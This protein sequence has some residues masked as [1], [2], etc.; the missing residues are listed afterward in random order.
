MKEVG[1]E[2]IFSKR[3]TE[4]SQIERVP[5]NAVDLAMELIARKSQ[6]HHKLSAEATV[7]YEQVR[8]HQLAIDLDTL[9]RRLGD[10]LPAITQDEF[11]TL[12]NDAA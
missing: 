4:L 8:H 1:G 10:Y 9:H 12:L 6:A 7:P 3:E 5:T 11:D 2:I